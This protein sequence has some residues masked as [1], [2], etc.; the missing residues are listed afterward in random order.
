MGQCEAIIHTLSTQ[1][2][3]CYD[4]YFSRV[5]TDSHTH[6]WAVGHKTFINDSRASLAVTLGSEF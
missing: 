2:L 6:V 4:F 5:R 3:G 1:L